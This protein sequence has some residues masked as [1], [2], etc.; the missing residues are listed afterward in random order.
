MKRWWWIVIVLLVFSGAW[1]ARR[2]R[3]G[4]RE[5]RFDPKAAALA[6][7]EEVQG[8]GVDLASGPCLGVIGPDWVADVAHEPRQPVDDEPTNQ[9]PEY[10]SGEATHFV[11]LTSD[12]T[13]IR[14][15]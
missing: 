3:S 11:E 10:R 5:T 14:V 15:R 4:V 9:C 8:E 7:F 2:G 6:R 13:V 1:L 12:G